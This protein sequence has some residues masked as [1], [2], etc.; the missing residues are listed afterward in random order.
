MLKARFSLHD[1]ADVEAFTARII[2]RRNLE[3][4][5]HDHEDLHA[6]LVETCW[7]LST[8]KPRPWRRSF[9]GWVQPLLILRVVDWR[10]QRY[11]R[12]R[13]TGSRF[14]RN[15][16]WNQDRTLPVFVPIDDRPNEPIDPVTVDT[17]AYSDTDARRLLRERCSQNP[18]SHSG[19][20]TVKDAR[21]A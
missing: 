3:L 5:W 9:S 19:M 14:D 17:G 13:Q 12:T 2:D 4:A 20:G 7:E 15:P 1:I 18:R 11:G 6:Y 21:A 16:Q 8:T 10:R